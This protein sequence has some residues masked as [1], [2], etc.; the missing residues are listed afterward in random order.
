MTALTIG[1]KP[2]F[3][4]RI[5][6]WAQFPEMLL[7]GIGQ[8]DF[9]NNWLTGLVILGGIFYNSPVYGVACLI[10]A[11]TATLT[12]MAL[13]ADKSLI[14]AGLFQFNGVLLAIG[15]VA[16]L[17]PDFTKGTWPSWQ[18]W[19]YVLFGSALTAVITAALMAVGERRQLSTLT[20]PFNLAAWL[21]IF[22]SLKLVQLHTGPNIMPGVP[23]PFHGPTGPYTLTTLYQ[24]VGN[25][26]AEVFF[27]DNWVAGYIILAGLLINSRIGAGM[28]L[29][30]SALGVGTA[31]VLGGNAADIQAGLFSFNDVLTAIALG[32]FFYVLNLRG[33]LYAVFGTVIT[34]WVWAT[35]AIAL[36]PVGMPAFTGPFCIVATFLILAK[37]RFPGLVAVPPAAATTPEG[38]LARRHEFEPAESTLEAPPAA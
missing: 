36:A 5:P 19:L 31:M 25:G 2:I 11:A 24:G 23:A 34:T 13:T 1:Q 30:G 33:F 14:D 6:R 7:R 8:V 9:Q 3:G 12:A 28:A 20:W 37:W 15:L 27:Q 32:G 38:N 21:F 16:Y 29:L 10:G 17:N 35:V 4:A 22:A 18:L 26:I